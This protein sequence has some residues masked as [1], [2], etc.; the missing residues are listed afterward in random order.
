MLTY[1]ACVFIVQTTRGEEVKTASRKDD[2]THPARHEVDLGERRERVVIR[3]NLVAA[4]VQEARHRTR[5]GL[6]R[7]VVRG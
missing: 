3:L 7:R 4:L 2:W 1:S 5:H 6:A